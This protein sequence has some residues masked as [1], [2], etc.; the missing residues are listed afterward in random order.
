MGTLPT[1]G[2]RP[3]PFLLCPICIFTVL[4]FFWPCY[5][6]AQ[7][8]SSALNGV[9]EDITG[10]R[11]ASA[12][13]TVANPENGFHREVVADASG[14]FS[15]SMLLPGRY[16]VTAWAK[17]MAT[18]TGTPVELYVG[19]VGQLQLRLAP[20]GRTETVAVH[21]QPEAQETQASGVSHVVTQEAIANLPLNGRRYTDL[22][23]LTP[24][25][26]QDPRG[27]TSN[28]NGDLAFGGIR[29]FQNNFLVDGADDNNTFY[30]Q[31]RGRYRA[32]YQFSNEVIKEF[33]VS[34]NSYS[35]ELGR[36]GGGVFNV[37]TKSGS[38]DW[39][40]GAFYYGRDRYFDA[41]QAFATC[42]P[43]DR[44]QQFGGTL[45]GPIRK[46]RAFFYA[47]FDENLLTVPSIMQFAN[48][49]ST[50]VPQP[51]DYDYTDKQ[52]V[53]AA[54]QQLN[55]MAGAYPTTMQGNAAFAK[56]DYTFSQKHL[57][58]V[59]LNTSRYNGTNN[60]FF[61]PSSELT[62]YAES[63]NGSEYVRTESLAASLVS[64]WTNNLATNLRAQFSRDDEQ[65]T[66]NSNQP[67]TKIYDLV[68]GFGRS[69]ILPRDTHEHKLHIADTLSYSTP[70]VQWKFGGDFIQ[71]WI[72]NYFPSM[73]GGEYYFDD[74][75]VNPW[76][77]APMKYGEPLTPLR[78]YA[79][80]VPRYYMQDFG[81]AV[82]HP[83]TRFY[84]A[85][86]QDSIRVTRSFTL[87]VGVRYDLQ[88]FEPG[89]LVT[90]PLYPPSGK[91]PTDTN[92]ISPRIGFAYSLGDRKLLVLR[93]GAG[94]FYTPIPA[95]YAS[96]VAID[97]GVTQSQLFLDLMTP[98]QAAVFPT[99][100]NPLVNCPPGT[101][102]CKP[103]ASIAG[104]VTTQ[105]SAFAPN[106]QTP[107]VEQANLTVERELGARVSISAA[108][109]YVHGVHLIRSLDVN[110]PE[111]TILDYPVYNDT[112]SVFLGM[113]QVASF[114]TWQTTRSVTCPYPPC[115]N[116]VQR[117]DPRL[118]TINSFE[119]GSSSVYNGM[120]VTLKRQ[121]NKGLFF[122]VAYTLAK[123]IDDGQD[124]L[125]V[126][127]PGN[128]QNVYATSLE[129]G[130]SVTDQR[131]RFLAAVVVEP[132][133]FKFENGV[134]SALANHW[135]VSSVVTFGSGRP[136]NAT[137][138]GD[139]NQDGNIYNDRLPGYNRN[140]F[141][142]PDYFTT[143][144]R[145]TRTLKMSDR[146]RLELLA[147]SFNL[148]NR[149]NSRV[150]ISDDGFYNSA[151]QFVAY[152]TKV[153]GKMYPGQFQVNSQFLLPTNAYAPRQIQLSIRLNF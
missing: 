147:E 105:V 87:N 114:A 51:A 82:S 29:G 38:N 134:L 128:V 56:V 117:P 104:L 137:M 76:T 153:N 47:G 4:I 11:V 122:R 136:F 33:R 17:D 118:G 139:A 77:Y 106:F 100:P 92:N 146:V 148:T 7:D 112:G 111:P 15:F 84:S 74:V 70:R 75:K 18:P 46:D 59:R 80:D 1:S 81:T 19:G 54:A 97:N 138:A 37:A 22:A 123:A 27:L 65:S 152:S 78:A 91:V 53:M 120:T 40:G 93:G 127:R 107:Y 130:L 45:G 151:G 48:G 61:D 23:L 110:L 129:R 32:P 101:M 71:A 8:G 86:M 16:I 52:L 88:T 68:A 35:A 96:Q 73:F 121:I 98:A 67:L 20:V 126:G 14:N 143:D 9:V 135:K 30:A 60:V 21:E 31:A 94:I 99:Y 85:F 89:P 119:S 108:Y 125:V 5:A 64:A 95:I 34:S 39:H 25:V 44:Q 12:A 90:N 144:M 10:A 69:S 41:Q 133:H 36:A 124:A 72:Y 6:L 116:E 63:E 102:V 115:I 28:S 24:G 145:V 149:T 150:V 109:L 13:V 3:L 66:A 49:A 131:N 141:I 83:N 2:I 142:G 113:D 79:H 140:A 57:A 103:P 132:R 50:V 58:F 42:K 43:D 26:T 62:S 55:T